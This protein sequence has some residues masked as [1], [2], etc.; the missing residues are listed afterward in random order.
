MLIPDQQIRHFFDALCRYAKAP[1]LS[2]NVL[3]PRSEL[4]IARDAV[5]ACGGTINTETDVLAS[6]SENAITIYSSQF[7]HTK[8]HP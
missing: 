5:G 2:E 6:P 7:N 1:R 4:Y 8:R 3:R